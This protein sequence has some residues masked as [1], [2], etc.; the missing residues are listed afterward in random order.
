MFNLQ[1]IFTVV[2]SSGFARYR[3]SDNRRRKSR[4]LSSATP[5]ERRME[6]ALRERETRGWGRVGV[7]LGGAAEGEL[8]TMVMILTIE[9][10]F[11]ILALALSW[12][13]GFFRRPGNRLEF[14][15][16]G[17]KPF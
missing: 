17:I 12:N 4:Q 11:R 6:M 14:T 5:L 2:G 3:P 9:C 13:L 8:L 1:R 16:F 15:L 7:L 10:D